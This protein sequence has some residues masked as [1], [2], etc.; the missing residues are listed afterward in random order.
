MIIRETVSPTK[1]NATESM[2]KKF[3]PITDGNW[4]IPG[5][6]FLDFKGMPGDN[7]HAGEG[8]EEKHPP[9]LN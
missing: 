6:S 7:T 3:F 1:K 9:G 5:A 8:I 2:D 4:Y